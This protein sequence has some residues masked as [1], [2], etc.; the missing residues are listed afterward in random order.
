MLNVILILIPVLAVKE[1][2]ILRI[3]VNVLQDFTV[4]HYWEIV[5]SVQIHVK[6]VLIQLVTVLSVQVLLLEI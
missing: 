5:L 6:L 4:V 2:G 3:I 1:E